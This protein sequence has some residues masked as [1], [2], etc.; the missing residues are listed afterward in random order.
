MINMGWGGGSGLDLNMGQNKGWSL[1]LRL[2]WRKKG[3]THLSGL[4]REERS[5]CEGVEWGVVLSFCFIPGVGTK[6]D[7]PSFLPIPGSLPPKIL[8]LG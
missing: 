6:E 7:E 5:T 8:S 4:E 1:G 3:R 2:S